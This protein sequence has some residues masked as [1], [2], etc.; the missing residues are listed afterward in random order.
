MNL[1][2]PSRE[3]EPLIKVKRLLCWPSKPRYEQIVEGE[4]LQQQ[5]VN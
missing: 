2:E 4:E 3:Y 5:Q 1:K